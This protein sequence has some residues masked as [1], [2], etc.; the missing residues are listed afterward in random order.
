MGPDALKHQPAEFRTK[1]WAV[2]A[3]GLLALP[4]WAAAI[5][6]GKCN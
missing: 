2:G 3:G 4:L 1:N 5:V 6:R